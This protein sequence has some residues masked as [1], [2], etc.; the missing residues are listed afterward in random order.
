ML[1]QHIQGKRARICRDD[2]QALESDD[3]YSSDAEL[4]STV[5]TDHIGLIFR[6]T[7]ALKLP[8]SQDS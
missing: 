7:L 3:H 8:L 2:V 1:L 5:G 6:T 4:R